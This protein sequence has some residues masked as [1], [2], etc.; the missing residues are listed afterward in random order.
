WG[1]EAFFRFLIAQA[2]AIMPVLLWMY[3]HNVRTTGEWMALNKLSVEWQRLPYSTLRTI[4]MPPGFTTWEWMTPFAD[5]FLPVG[6]KSSMTAYAFVTS[7]FGE[8]SFRQIGDVW[9]WGIL[10]LH[11]GWGIAGLFQIRRTRI[12]H[13]LGIAGAAAWLSM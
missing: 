13:L 9:V 4:L 6:K 8:Y 3:V 1:K 7:V 2:V 12:N 11:A 10:W 5:A